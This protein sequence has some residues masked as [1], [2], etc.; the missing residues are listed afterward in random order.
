MVETTES[1]KRGMNRVTMTVISPR[2]ENRPSRGSNQRPPVLKSATLS[3]E[4]WGLAYI[5]YKE[6]TLYQAT[7]Q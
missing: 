1:G 7:N 3:T 5:A 4:L 6:S 2:K